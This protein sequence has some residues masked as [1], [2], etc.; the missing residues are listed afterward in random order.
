MCL[1]LTVN[2]KKYRNLWRNNSSRWEFCRFLHSRCVF[3]TKI[4][5]PIITTIISPAAAVQ[6]NYY[7]GLGLRC[8]RA[9]FHTRG[10]EIEIIHRKMRPAAFHI[11]AIFPM[12][13]RYAP[14]T[15][16]HAVF[17]T[18]APGRRFDT[19]VSIIY[20]PTKRGW[21]AQSAAND[22]TD[23]SSGWKLFHGQNRTVNARSY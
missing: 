12:V 15:W 2:S 13:M 9:Q 21:L 8:V 18:P 20:T 7:L 10:V 3:V 23:D 14:A 5:I 19:R 22:P 6:Y 4:I 17:A 11:L 16:P 1:K